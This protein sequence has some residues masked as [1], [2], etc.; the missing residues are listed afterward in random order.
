M[1]TDPSSPT[2]KHTAHLYPV[3][4]LRAKNTW[5]RR[6]A[7]QI[8]AFFLALEAATKGSFEEGMENDGPG[9]SPT[10]LPSHSINYSH[11]SHLQT[12]YTS[13]WLWVNNSREGG[14]MPG[15]GPGASSYIPPYYL[16]ILCENPSGVSPSHRCLSPHCI[17]KHY[18]HV[19][20]WWW[21]GLKP[22]KREQCQY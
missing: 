20:W 22:A 17:K 5:R 14:I 15:C 6:S 10:D 11:C 3:C 16:R 13:L 18:Q 12:S 8:G 7:N 1:A 4:K 21:K 9:N 19:W 2:L